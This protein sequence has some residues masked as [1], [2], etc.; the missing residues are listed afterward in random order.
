[1]AA[2]GIDVPDIELVI[3]LDPPKDADSYV[4]RS[5]RTGRAGR[6]GRSVMIVPPRARR[7]VMRILEMARIKAEWEPAPSANKV[8][9]QLR[10][11]FRHQLHQRLASEVS[12]TQRQ[13]DYAKRLLDGRDPAEVV[14][15]L[16]E[17]AQPVPAREPMEIRELANDVRTGQETAPGFVRFRVN[18]GERGGAAANRLL[19]HVCRRGEIRGQ[20]VGAID[21]G[22][23]ESTFE[24]AA[25]VA[26]RFEKLVRR[27]DPRDPKLRIV[28][29]G[30]GHPGSSGGRP[31]RPRPNARPKKRFLPKRKDRS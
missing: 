13:I 14:A 12:P 19:G 10:K 29:V 23:D 26:T 21:I 9:K 2:R 22:P 30:G 31:A 3:H 27:P 4:H 6:T 20:L 7:N 25:S 5:G 11:R 28:R 24:V 17:L 16:L 15:L 18:W 8:N 1:V